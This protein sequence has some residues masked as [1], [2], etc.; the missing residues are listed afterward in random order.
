MRKPE[1][2]AEEFLPGRK[3][4]SSMRRAV[5]DC[6]GCELYKNA[7]Q[8]VFGRGDSK[9]EIMFVGEQPGDSEDK[10]GLAFSGPAGRLLMSAVAKAGIEPELTYFTN[11]VKHFGF[12]E[13]GK[14]RL[15]KKPKILN[16]RACKP[17]LEAEIG[18]VKPTVIV[19]LGSSATLAVT[20]K[21]HKVTQLR[22]KFLDINLEQKVMITVH[23]A[24]ILRAAPEDRDLQLKMFVAD[25]KKVAKYLSG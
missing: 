13:R 22:G 4:I 25:L 18:A 20:G 23:P 2:S 15:H 16:I 3:S 19:C 21:P 8:A 17:W 1:H 6:E 12:Q 5:Q 14:R 11:A 7:T 24:S 9:A 10:N